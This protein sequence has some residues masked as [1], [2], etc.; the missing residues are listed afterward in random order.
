MVG[1]KGVTILIYWIVGIAGVIGAL[2]RYW[3]EMILPAVSFAGFPLST[4]LVNLSAF[5][6]QASLRGSFLFFV[7]RYQSPSFIEL[8]H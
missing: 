3:V 7:T 1:K 6:I 5:Y 2:L 4:L 8:E